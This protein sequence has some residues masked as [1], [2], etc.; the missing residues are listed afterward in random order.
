MAANPYSQYKEQSLMTMTPEQLVV[1]L[2]NGCSKNLNYAKIHIEEKRYDAANISLQKAKKIIRYLDESLDH[3]YE[4]SQNLASLYDYFARR[5]V[6]ANIKK[7]ITILDEIIPMIDQLG[8]SFRQA[9]KIVR[10]GKK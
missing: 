2:F 1:E 5:I 6:E 9:E 3:K 4:I 7:D 10:G 8:D